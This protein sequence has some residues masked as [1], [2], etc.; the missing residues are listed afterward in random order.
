MHEQ[1]GHLLGGN[2]QN[3]KDKLPDL[4]PSDDKF[5]DHGVKYRTEMNE[6][7]KCDHYFKYVEG[8][9]IMCVNCPIGYF[10]NGDQKVVD[11]KLLV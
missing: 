4:P 8:Q 5:F 2:M 11:G 9:Q 1:V 3:G 6:R 10:L 7:E